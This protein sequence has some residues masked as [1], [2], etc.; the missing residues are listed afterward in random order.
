MIMTVKEQFYKYITQLQ[1]EICSALELADGSSRFI[2]DV[3]TREE[4]GGGTSRVIS[5]GKV[6]EKGG[7][8]IS[9]VHGEL[10]KQMRE[11]F[12]VEGSNFFACGLSLVI[13]PVNPYVPTVH[14]NWRYF[15]LYNDEG[16]VIDTWFGGGSDLTPYYIFE[17]DGIHF[18]KTLKAA[19][20]AFGEELYP[21]YKAHCDQYFVNKHRNN[22]ARG[23][24]GVFYDYL[25]P[26]DPE[27]AERLV[28]F[29]KANGNA[30]LAAY[31]PI[32]EK[33]KEHP[34]SEREVEWQEIRRGRY[35]EFNLV[36][37]RGTLFGL[38][39]N[40]RIESILMSMPPRARWEY[41]YRPAAGTEEARLLEFL[42]PRE[43]ASQNLAL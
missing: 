34:Y 18:H 21:K 36:H 17:E 29:Q 22:E 11:T 8:N 6:F 25:R 37:D 2:T 32:V 40:G 7:V 26:R 4:G 12:G 43:W 20:D 15:E 33:R 28:S 42:K 16:R 23:I 10:P 35:A 31:L 19:M 13:H 14:A 1:E 5:K 38:R 39:T 24:G 9:A 3:W 30:F 27:D 41:N